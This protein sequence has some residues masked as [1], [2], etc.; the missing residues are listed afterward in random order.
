[1]HI[2]LPGVN[3]LIFFFVI[4]DIP[5]TLQNTIE[6]TGVQVEGNKW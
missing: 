6:N 1:M 2:I 5:H 4:L 3:F